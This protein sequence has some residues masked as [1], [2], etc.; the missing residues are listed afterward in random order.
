MASLLLPLPYAIIE[1]GGG[2]NVMGSLI[3]ISGAKTYPANG[4]LLL[5]TVYATSPDSSLFAFNVLKAWIYGETIVLP[6]DVV[7]PAHTSTKE[8][9]AS[10]T[11][12]MVGSQ[13][14][15]T[16]A[17]LTYLGYPVSTKVSKNKNGKKK[18]SYSFPFSVSIHLPD[19]GGPSGGLI[20]AL[21]IVEKLT[22]EDLLA[23]RNVAGTGTISKS[24]HVGGIGGIDEKLIAARRAGATLFLA[25]VENCQDIDHVPTGIKVFVVATLSEAVSVLR[26]STKSVRHCAWQG[27]R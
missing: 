9:D 25:P 6:R 8:I 14:A 20:F 26:D 18:I 12:Q 23:G 1:P 5:T 2:K 19:T 3:T 22:P 27:I 11:A 7:Y 15:A 13:Q 10:N 4:K 24:G 21:G 16:A 17:A